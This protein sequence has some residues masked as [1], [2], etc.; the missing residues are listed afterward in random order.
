MK[1]ETDLFKKL[2]LLT[3]EY[4]RI[5]SKMVANNPASQELDEENYT[6][7]YKWLRFPILD[8]YPGM[9]EAR[10]REGLEY[11]AS[12][13][14]SGILVEGLR[15]LIARVGLLGLSIVQDE[16]LFQFCISGS[17]SL[18]D[19]QNLCEQYQSDHG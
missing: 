15:N 9:Q 7:S 14:L 2:M 6:H 13:A 8:E 5:Q 18:K 17:I 10:I 1:K 12:D 3:K 4:H 11:F 16:S 19:I